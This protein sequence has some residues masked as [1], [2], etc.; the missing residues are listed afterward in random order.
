M[1]VFRLSVLLGK[2]FIIVCVTTNPKPLNA[3]I[4]RNTK[5]PISQ[6]YPNAT[7]R[8]IFNGFKL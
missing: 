8:P 1:A 4:H 3:L 7:K 5:D 6:A 2:Q